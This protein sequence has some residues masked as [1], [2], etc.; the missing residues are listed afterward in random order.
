M[1][2]SFRHL[3]AAETQT[4]YIAVVFAVLAILIACLGLFGLV[5]FAAEQRTREIGIRKVLG[6][7]VSTIVKLIARDFLGLV[8]IASVIAFPIAFWAMSHWLLGF[9]YRIGISWWIFAGAAL[10]ALLIA[11][12]TV[13]FQAIRAALVNPVDSLRTE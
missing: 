13:S 11:L 3:Y 4:G 6:A 2:D 7:R 9:A 1:D 10:L 5:T 12:A 8:V